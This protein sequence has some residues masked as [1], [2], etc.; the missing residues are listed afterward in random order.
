MTVGLAASA[1]FV[2]L[3]GGLFGGSDPWAI[4]VVFDGIWEAYPSLK[5]S[6]PSLVGNVVVNVVIVVIFVGFYIPFISSAM[7]SAI[8]ARLV[9]GIWEAYPSLIDSD[10]SLVGNIVSNV[11]IVAIFSGFFVSIISS[12]IAAQLAQSMIGRVH[13]VRDGN[14]VSDIVPRRAKLFS[15]F[16]IVAVS[17]LLVTLLAFAGFFVIDNLLN[18]SRDASC[19]A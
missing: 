10:P 17:I 6:D 9:D 3:L 18:Y 4:C 14:L 2:A 11:A 15:L 16:S 1:A 12:A 19:R 7:G 13:L 8:D 5:D